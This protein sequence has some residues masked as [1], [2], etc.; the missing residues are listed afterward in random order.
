LYE[1][2]LSRQPTAE[3][4]AVATDILG[5]P[6]TEQG[7]EDVLWIIMMLPEFQIVR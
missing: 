7:I 4:L 2:A 6:P 3:E 5:S 1:S